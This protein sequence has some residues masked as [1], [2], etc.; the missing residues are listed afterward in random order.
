MI[1]WP[2]YPYR[3]GIAHH[4]NNF[5]NALT[6]LG[7]KVW[8]FTFS[9]QYPKV[10]YPGK[11]QLEP[12]WTENP[13][14]QTENLTINR[15]IDTLNPFSWY[16][17]AQRIIKENPDV[18]CIKYWHPYFVPCFTFIIWF[19]RRRGITVVCIIDNLFPHERHKGDALLVRFLLSQVGWAVTQS[20][21]VHK[22]FQDF[23]PH[24]PEIMIPHPVYDQFWP[25][26]SQKE[27]RQKLHISD[28]K[29]VL[30][31]FGF[32]RP[33]KGLDILLWIMRQLILK[34]PNIHLVIAWECFGSFEMYQEIIDTFDLSKYITLHIKYIPNIDIPIYF[35]AC[36]LL[37]MPYRSMTNSGIENIG[38]IY[39]NKY[40]LT[41]WLSWEQLYAR[42][43]A[44][45]MIHVEKVQNNSFTWRIYSQKLLL[46]SN[47]RIFDS[48]GY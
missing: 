9:R 43:I 48:S 47:S 23:F 16:K 7:N 19:L 4:T 6:K 26:V 1:I 42:I 12:I 8:I 44:D 20:E 37:V 21:V 45:L 2:A 40:L 10:L 33:Y 32:I 13:F 3:W 18:C 31:F 15:T 25:P 29:K 35:G 36:D 24:I 30:L 28:N 22:Q 38:K 39:A 14:A 34:F 27:A 5:A 41:I 17:T 46:F 11:A